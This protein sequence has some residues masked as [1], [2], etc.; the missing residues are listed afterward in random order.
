MPA[1]RAD[2]RMAADGGCA[3]GPAHNRPVLRTHHVSLCRAASSQRPDGPIKRGP[4]CK[5]RS[6]RDTVERLYY[7]VVL[8]RP[9]SGSDP[10]TP[11]LAGGRCVS[12]DEEENKY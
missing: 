9:S 4:A 12:V 2:L 7:V 8:D 11:L 6:A 1:R 10:D 3:E 5:I